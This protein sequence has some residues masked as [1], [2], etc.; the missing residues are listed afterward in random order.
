MKNIKWIVVSIVPIFTFSLYSEKILFQREVQ[1]AP[2]KVVTNEVS[3]EKR[4]EEKKQAEQKK[5]KR[6][7]S[8]SL[9]HEN[10]DGKVY[11]QK[12]GFLFANGKAS[13]TLEIAVQK[14]VP[15]RI[16]YSLNSG[17]L[18]GY[19][20]PFTIPEE[21]KYHIFYFSKDD[22]DNQEI[23]KEFSVTIDNTSP[24]LSI[25]AIGA[26]QSQNGVLLTKPGLK[27]QVIASDNSSGLKGV[28][29][30]DGSGFAPVK[31]EIFELQ[32][33]G[34]FPVSFIAEDNLGNRTKPIIINVISDNKKP[35][36]NYQISQL[37]EVGGKSIC[38]PQST[39]TVIGKDNESGLD[40]ILYR[41]KGVTEWSVYEKP[42]SLMRFND[43]NLEIIAY[44]K[45]GNSSDILNIECKI[46]TTP[47]DSKIILQIP[48]GAK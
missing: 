42:I 13:F 30:N 5:L 36:L 17:E 14:N 15:V 43:L 41:K 25:N 18:Q 8:S 12:D 23:K 24:K 48:E 31:D 22:L 39:L 2:R 11:R 26:P 34:N 27:F 46:D 21:G 3:D 28:Y 10:Q 38:S 20:S 44:D 16:F 6:Q 32:N 33:E 47:P 37:N 7:I 29:A 45:G 40:K 9:S 19:S 1:V 4:L 35:T